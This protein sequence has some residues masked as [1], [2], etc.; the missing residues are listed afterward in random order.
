MYPKEAT[1][2]RGNHKRKVQK[3][4]V[5]HNTRKKCMRGLSS[6]SP[7]GVGIPEQGGSYRKH[8]RAKK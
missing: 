1:I 8:G 3:R 7:S 5:N 2:Y 6:P 4:I